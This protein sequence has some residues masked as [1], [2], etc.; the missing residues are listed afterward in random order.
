[1]DKKILIIEDEPDIM[2]Y[3]QTILEANGYEPYVASGV[4]DAWDLMKEVQ[5]DLICLDIMMPEETGIS[6]YTRLRDESKYDRIPVMVISGVI[7]KGEF[8][9]RSFVPDEKYPP[10]EHYMEKPI[11]VDDFLNKVEKLTSSNGDF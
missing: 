7:Q 1:M 4:Q 8:D 6:F 11:K 5:P 2:T 9:F 10:P 3:L